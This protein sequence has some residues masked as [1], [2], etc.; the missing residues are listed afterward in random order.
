MT[1]FDTPEDIWFA[2]LAA[3]KAALKLELRGL[4]RHGRTAYSI[5]KS[6]YGLKGTREQV[7][8]QMERLVQEAIQRHNQP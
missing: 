4:S 3:R 2:Q 5:C 1:V 8:A 7:L 6:E